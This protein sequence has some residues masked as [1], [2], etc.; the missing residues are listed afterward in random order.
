MS[1][2]ASGPLAT[3]KRPPVLI[4]IAVAVL[5]LLVWLVVYFLPQ[6]SKI[7]K[8]DAQEQ[9]LEQKVAAVQARVALLKK[10]FAHM[11]A[12]ASMERKLATYAPATP[13]EYNYVTSLHTAVNSSVVTLTSISPGAITASGTGSSASSAS[14]ASTVSTIPFTLVVK[15][16][17][18]HL[19]SLINNIYALPRLTDIDSIDFTGGGPGTNRTTPLSATF[20]LTIFTTAKPTPIT[21]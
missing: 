13:D 15:G 16:T 11:P 14:S 20:D 18:D 8:L 6:G 12:I 7:S 2:E 5:V 1:G 17:Y 4:A 3:L 10:T 9:S 21:P 19:L